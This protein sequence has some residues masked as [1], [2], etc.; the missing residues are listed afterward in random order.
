MDFSEL[1]QVGSQV[2]WEPAISSHETLELG[3]L[4]LPH[5]AE[6][7]AVGFKGDNP[8][9]TDPEAFL[10]S[11][12]VSVLRK[13]VQ[14]IQPFIQFCEGYSSCRG[15]CPFH[16]FWRASLGWRCGMGEY[17]GHEQGHEQGHDRCTQ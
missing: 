10:G 16:N 6:P 1:G 12:E 5:Y 14:V 13:A 2:I 4:R 8:V 9:L 7:V 17:Q 11:G 3:G 15:I